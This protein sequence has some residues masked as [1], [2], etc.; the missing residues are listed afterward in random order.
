MLVDSHCHLDFPDLAEDLDEVVARARQAG[1][2]P[3]LTICTHVTR[4]ERVLAVAR[5]FEGVDCTVGIHPHEAGKEPETSAE[6]LMALANDPKVIGFGETGLDFFYEHS[7]RDA[8]ERSFRKHIRAARESGLPVIV[9][10]RDADA[11]TMRIL[12]EEQAKGP[13]AGLI[14]CFSSSAELAE[15]AVELGMMVSISGIVTFKKAEALRETVRALPLD[16][17][18]VETDAPYLAP[19][20]KRGKRNE[21]AFTA[22]T[23]AT[24]AEVKGISEAELARAT[25]DNFFRLFTKARR[26]TAVAAAE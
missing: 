13:F 14:H 15:K 2:G 4:F 12:E 16:H 7:P 17:L 1:V 6:T 25:T 26:P 21:P 3:M 24:V 23:A 5:R 8:Q 11:D 20:P 19:V 22:Y 9:H 10:T 18:L